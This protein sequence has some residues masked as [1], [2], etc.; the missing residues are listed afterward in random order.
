MPEDARP[1]QSQSERT[2]HGQSST[3]SERPGGP[4]ARPECCRDWRCGEADPYCWP[5]P[6]YWDPYCGPRRHHWPRF[7]SAPPMPDAGFFE[8]MMRFAAGAAGFRGRLW[9]EMADAAHYGQGD[10]RH[11]WASSPYD[12]DPCPPPWSS[13]DPWAAPR[14]HCDPCPPPNER[15][16]EQDASDAINLKELRAT[17]EAGKEEKLKKMR[18]ALNEGKSS[19]L[20]KASPEHLDKLRKELAYETSKAEAAIDAVI[21]DVKLARVAEAMRRKRWSREAPPGRRR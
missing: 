16:D 8:A 3:A 20:A 17:L 11:P 21:H 12:C 2:N 13:C 4:R 7:W 18:A 19:D 14:S 10:W 1:D 6:P 9:R 15:S 5:A